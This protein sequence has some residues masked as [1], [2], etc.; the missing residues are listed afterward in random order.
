[1]KPVELV[2]GE[3]VSLP[4]FD[5]NDM[6]L[7]LVTDKK[8]NQPENLIEKDFDK[9]SWKSTKTMND[10]TGDDFI[11]D[12][13]SGTFYHDGIELSKMSTEAP[14]GVNEVRV[15]G[16]Q[17]FIDKSHSDHMGSLAT[18]P[19]SFTLWCF[20]NIMRRKNKAWQTLAYIPNLD[21]GQGTDKEYDPQ[22]AEDQAA[23][24]KS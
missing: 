13:N 20:N 10:W 12:V 24:E 21:V 1:M 3:I 15:V 16:L 2:G 19:V 8:L 23:G 17:L 4:Y 5:F 11:D 14:D 7:S 22:G 18:T 9:T 6:F